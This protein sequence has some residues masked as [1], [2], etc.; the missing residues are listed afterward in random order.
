MRKTEIE[1]GML[2]DVA[3]WF[4]LFRILTEI[5]FIKDHN[6]QDLISE[7]QKM[8]TGERRFGKPVILRKLGVW[9][10]IKKCLKTIPPEDYENFEDSLKEILV[11][12]LK[13]LTELWEKI[14]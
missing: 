7:I 12:I 11:T 1:I 4:C 13:E 2:Y 9:N 14:E 6:I 8:N 10:E 5:K 3:E